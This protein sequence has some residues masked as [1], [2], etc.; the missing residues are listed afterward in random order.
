[1]ATAAVTETTTGKASERVTGPARKV[2]NFMEK[3]STNKTLTVV[4]DSAWAVTVANVKKTRATTLLAGIRADGTDSIAF[5][6]A[7]SK[8]PV[9]D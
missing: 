6:G 3:Q 7:C 9:A 4:P 2:R 5:P 1:M 8:H